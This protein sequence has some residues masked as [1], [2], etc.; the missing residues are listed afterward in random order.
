[1]Q[2][3]RTYIILAIIFAMAVS[4]AVLDY[5]QPYNNLQ[6]KP[7]AFPELPFKLGLDLQGGTHLIYEADLSQLPKEA[8]DSSMQGLRDVIERR[9]NLFG[10]AEPVV[11][12]QEAGEHYRLIVELAGVKDPDQAIKM[13]G[14]T[15]FLEFKEAKDDTFQ[16][17]ILTG[18]YLEKAEPGFDQTTYQP[19]VT[20]KFNS[21]GAEIFKDIT[22]RNIGKPLAI[23]IDGIP[24]SVPV[25]QEV[26]PNGEARITGTFSIEQ[27]RELARNLNAGALP[28]PIKLIS[29]QNV[30][31]TLGL[32]S[33]TASLKAA[34]F[35]FLA[36]VIFIVLFYR[37]SGL[38]AAIALVIYVIFVL[39]LFKLIPV[40]LTLAG[41]G[42]FILSIGMAV[43]ANILIF[44]R[45]RE[46]LKSGQSF[47]IAVEEGFRRAWP[48]IRDGNL[49][50]LIVAVILFWFGTSFVKGF[51]FTLTIGILMSMFS[52]III[53]KNLLRLFVGTKLE[54]VKILW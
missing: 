34:L 19:L 5:P 9:V 30:G 32:A 44:S 14:Q 39:A 28:V 41:I 29:Q 36:V 50:T 20:L 8:Y 35:G 4:A 52:A 1:M 21:E 53:T 13:I 27:V 7:V 18:K 26:I 2:K 3:Q 54:K 16:S 6:F 37:L 42:G 40:T 46:E 43:D 49:T 12:V 23:Y 38:L 15:P 22:S 48:S 10:V 25:V 17:T 24:I 47:S 51:A 33:L 11:Q 31:P 45:M